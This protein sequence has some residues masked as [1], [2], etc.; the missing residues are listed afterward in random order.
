M[1][2][3]GLIHFLFTFLY[4]QRLDEGKRTISDFNAAPVEVKTKAHYDELPHDCLNIRKFP[5]YQE[6]G[7]IESLDTLRDIMLRSACSIKH[8]LE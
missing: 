2:F 3:F 6:E 1:T 8:T 4:I 5:Q 7:I